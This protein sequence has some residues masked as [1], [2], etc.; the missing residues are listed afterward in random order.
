MRCKMACVCA[1]FFV[2]AFLASF[3]LHAQSAN[4][5]ETLNQYISDLQRTKGSA[6][7]TGQLLL[8]VPHLT[9]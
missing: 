6:L 5:Q 9:S 1:F 4:P 2:A 8:Q 3:S 7:D